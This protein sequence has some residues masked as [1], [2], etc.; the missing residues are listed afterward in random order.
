MSIFRGKMSECTEVPGYFSRR[1]MALRVLRSLPVDIQR[2]VFSLIFPTLEKTDDLFDKLCDNCSDWED[3]NEA[4]SEFLHC[5]LDEMGFPGIEP[6]EYTYVKHC[7]DALN[8]ECAFHGR[9]KK[10]RYVS[11]DSWPELLILKKPAAWSLCSDVS[12]GACVPFSRRYLFCD[13]CKYIAKK[14]Q[15]KSYHNAKDR[16]LCEQCFEAEEHTDDIYEAYDQIPNTIEIEVPWQYMCPDGEIS[17]I[18]HD[19]PSLGQFFVSKRCHS[20]QFSLGA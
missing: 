10:A 17:N 4:L 1:V 18:P 2:A 20:H 11:S 15:R 8:L 14:L 5:D 7:C 12:A 3:I 16:Q 6:L 19:P 9:N 13:A